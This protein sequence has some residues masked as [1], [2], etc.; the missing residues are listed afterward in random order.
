MFGRN[1]VRPLICFV[2][3]LSFASA[4]WAAVDTLFQAPKSYSA[5]GYYTQGIILTDVN[6][7][8]K[9]DAV[10]AH[11]CL[12]ATNCDTGAVSVLLGNGDGTFRAAQSYSSGAWNSLSVAVADINGDTKPD[13]IIAS[14]DR[15]GSVA[16]TGLISVMFGNGDGTF[17]APVL[18]KSG[19]IGA[20]SVAVED[21]NGD[22]IPDLLVANYCRDQVHCAVVSDSVVGVLLGNGNGT[23]QTAQTYIT[24]GFGTDFVAVADMNR[25]GKPDLIISNGYHNTIGVLLGNGDGSFQTASI[26]PSGGKVP[27][28]IVVADFNGDGKL[29]VAVTN[30]HYRSRD[31]YGD[32]SRVGVM[33]GNG[34]GTLRST[35]S[36]DSSAWNATG[37]TAADINGDGKLDLLIGTVGVVGLQTMSGNGDGTFQPAV[38]HAAGGQG[39]SGIAVM[40][41]TGDGKPEVITSNL[42][43][44]PCDAGAVGVLFSWFDPATSLK[45]SLNPATYGETVNLT[46]TLTWDGP[47]GIPT[48]N[49]VFKS[50]GTPIGTRLL[51]GGVATLTKTNLPAGN[52]A[53]TADY[54]GD[55]QFAKNSAATNQSIN[56]ATTTMGIKSSANPSTLGQAVTFTATLTSPTAKAAGTVTFMAGTTPLGTVAISSGKA[57]LT[58]STLPKGSAVITAIYAGTANIIGSAESLTQKVQ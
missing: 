31:P 33:L 48:G 36:Y 8:G 27:K 44:P 14:R 28:A 21:V 20:W 45:S 42:C 34:D 41:L 10:V 11:Q 46:A 2:I 5:G 38:H 26:Y 50:G 53:I 49:V 56:Q 7:D 1:V 23:F 58:T 37:I 18:Y 29:D 39:T 40:D 24:G 19:G 4:S 43:G 35:T 54:L 47:G 22:G 12:S 57:K 25:D 30:Q 3:L 55:V 15:N 17:R 16:D 52:L 13:L 6:G 9:P 32:R 51:A